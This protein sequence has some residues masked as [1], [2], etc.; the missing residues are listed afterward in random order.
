MD[1]RKKP[2]RDNPWIQK[3]ILLRFGLAQ[4]DVSRRDILIPIIKV[5]L[6]E[7]KE[8][9][10]E[11]IEEAATG[12]EVVITRAGGPAVRLTFVTPRKQEAQGSRRSG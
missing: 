12:E 7:A 6:E 10:G 5:S 9:L 2:E 1:R 8:H 3:V 11:L 4:E